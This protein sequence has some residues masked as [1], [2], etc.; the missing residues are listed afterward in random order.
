MCAACPAAYRDYKDHSQRIA[1]SCARFYQAR[2]APES[3]V[4]QS[5]SLKTGHIEPDVGMVLI[6]VSPKN[7]RTFVCPLVASRR[8]VVPQHTVALEC[9]GFV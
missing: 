5:G 3:F 2:S 7:Y 8:P 9:F 1:I 4:S 6:N